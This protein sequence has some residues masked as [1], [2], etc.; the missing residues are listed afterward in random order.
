ML[1]I[2]TVPSSGFILT[3]SNE[4]GD[5]FL[6][7]HTKFTCLGVQPANPAPHVWRSEKNNCAC[8]NVCYGTEVTS[9]QFATSLIETSPPNL[10]WTSRVATIWG[11]VITNPYLT[12]K[13]S[14][15]CWS[16]RM[17]TLVD[18]SK[19]RTDTDFVACTGTILTLL[20]WLK[21]EQLEMIL[22]KY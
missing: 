5:I 16:E 20:R 11:Q 4:F 7:P 8:L 22:L 10:V 6:Y 18:Q 9:L 14:L 3:R 19:I 1:T 17:Q 2:C 21:T 12:A 13:Y 15:Y